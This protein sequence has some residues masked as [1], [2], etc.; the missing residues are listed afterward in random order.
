M[1]QILVR[2]NVH[3]ETD[4]QTVDFN[5]GLWQGENSELDLGKGGGLVPT[6]PFSKHLTLRK[7]LHFTMHTFVVIS[8][9]VLQLYLDLKKLYISYCLPL[10][11]FPSS[12]D[13]LLMPVQTV[14]KNKK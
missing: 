7:I 6:G 13:L 3:Q 14:V 1:T 8:I 12:T 4:A 10:F 11:I 2:Q 5:S 9:C